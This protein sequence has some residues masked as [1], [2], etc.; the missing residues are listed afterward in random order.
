MGYNEFP[1]TTAASFPNGPRTKVGGHDGTPMMSEPPM[2]TAL[3]RT[4]KLNYL[5]IDNSD[6]L[7]SY[8]DGHPQLNRHQGMWYPEDPSQIE[9]GMPRFHHDAVNGT[10]ESHTKVRAGPRTEA[11]RLPPDPAYD[12]PVQVPPEGHSFF[13]AV[14]S[15]HDI[16]DHWADAMEIPDLRAVYHP[17]MPLPSF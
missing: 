15:K 10:K 8:H 16:V 11:R 4:H 9:P 13:S 5:N 12:T 2:Y 17:G 7:R 3:P 1:Y 6:V 14:L